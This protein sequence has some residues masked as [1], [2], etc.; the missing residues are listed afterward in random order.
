MPNYKL[1]FTDLDGTLLYPDISSVT[2]ENL[3]AI[4]ELHKMGVQVIPCSGRPFKLIPQILRENPFIRYISTSNGTVILDTKTEEPIV[5]NRLCAEH[6]RILVDI[7]CKYDIF[8]A[9]HM[10]GIDYCDR[11]FFKREN[12]E[13]YGL[14]SFFVEYF[15]KHAI[16]VDGLM[17]MAADEPTL[18]MTCSFIA[19]GEKRRELQ[20]ELERTG[21]FRTA[22]SNPNNFEAFSVNAGK[23]NAL[24]AL[25]ERLG[26]DISETIA[27]GDSNNDATMIE[28]AGL[29]LA[30]ENALPSLKEIADE[31]ICP[32]KD[33][34]LDYILN[35]Y[36]L[37]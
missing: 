20:A 37:K 24:R 7:L 36:I 14:D 15:E 10:R 31:V 4:E 33:H 16:K 28:A 21:L 26:V 18:A 30:V 12:Y 32:H 3:R 35:H 22:Q 23:G 8:P 19:D 6:R 17:Q 34:V 1:I 29:G 11:S 25:A 13:R 2:P 5:D 9:F 27:V